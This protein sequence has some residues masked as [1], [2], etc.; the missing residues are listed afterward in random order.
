[1]F[2]AINKLPHG[3]HKPRI[4]TFFEILLLFSLKRWLVK[5]LPSG[6]NDASKA[7]DEVCR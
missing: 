4:N 6:T 1:M 7:L 5:P 3:G 2:E